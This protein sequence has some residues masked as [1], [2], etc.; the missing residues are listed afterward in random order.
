MSVSCELSLK[1]LTGISSPAEVNLCKKIPVLFS[2]NVRE[3]K[4]AA[5]AKRVPAL[6]LLLRLLDLVL[7]QIS[8]LLTFILLLIL[9]T[10]ELLVQS[11][12]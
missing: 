11:V 2:V 8:K 1:L 9:V 4:F 10:K 5:F 12:N 3:T 6:K 7:D